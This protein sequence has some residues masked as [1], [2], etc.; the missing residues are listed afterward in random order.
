MDFARESAF[1]PWQ[2]QV[3]FDAR[4]IGSGLLQAFTAQR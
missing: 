4:I 2:G 1:P 3:L